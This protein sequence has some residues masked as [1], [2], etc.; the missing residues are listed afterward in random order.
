VSSIDGKKE[1]PLFSMKPTAMAITSDSRERLVAITAPSRT[2]TGTRET[3]PSGLKSVPPQ[4]V[5]LFFL[6][7]ANNN[8]PCPELAKLL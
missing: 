4:P 6:L 3:Q 8:T 7:H 5:N 2:V 1:R